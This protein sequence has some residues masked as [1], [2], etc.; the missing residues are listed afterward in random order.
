MRTSESVDQ[1]AME[2][3]EEIR[4][5]VTMPQAL[6][7]VERKLIAMA[8]NDAELEGAL[9]VPKQ[10]DPRNGTVTRAARILGMKRTTL[11]MKV[12]HDGKGPAW[13]LKRKYEKTANA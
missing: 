2:L 6:Y 9:K 5:G 3:Y 4:S 1:A 7:M 8:F 13:Y 12:T 11:S 10:R